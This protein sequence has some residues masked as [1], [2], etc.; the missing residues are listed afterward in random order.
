[1]DD[2]VGRVYNCVKMLED[3]GEPVEAFSCPN[4]EEIATFKFLQPSETCKNWKMW[5]LKDSDSQET[6]EICEDMPSNLRERVNSVLGQ[7]EQGEIRN[8]RG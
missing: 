6:I 2:I 3:S 7:I 8:A 5:V 1:M 4:L